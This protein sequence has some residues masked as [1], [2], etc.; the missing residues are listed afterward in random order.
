MVEQVERRRL[1]VVERPAAELEQQPA[2]RLHRVALRA[3]LV[4][5]ARPPAA[6]GEETALWCRRA[7]P[8][9]CPQAKSGNVGDNT[10]AMFSSST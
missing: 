3:R 2:E 7:R 8:T 1:Q 5:R 4:L 10:R 9:L 6:L